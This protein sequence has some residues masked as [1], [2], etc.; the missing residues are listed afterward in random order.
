MRATTERLE[1]IQNDL[2]SLFGSDLH[3]KW[4]ALCRMLCSA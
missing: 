4:S 3:A 1:F 2:A